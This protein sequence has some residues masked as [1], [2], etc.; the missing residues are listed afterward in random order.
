MRVFAR[1]VS[2]RQKFL[3]LRKIKL[4]LWALIARSASPAGQFGANREQIAGGR[5]IPVGFISRWLLRIRGERLG[6]NRID[7]GL[8]A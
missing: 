2:F 5:L 4:P 7:N 8:R 1:C 3:N 6:A